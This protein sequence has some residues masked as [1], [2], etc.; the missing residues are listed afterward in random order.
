[1]YTKLAQLKRQ[2]SAT[3]R[4]LHQP[5]SLP[6]AFLSALV[7]HIGRYFSDDHRSSADEQRPRRHG[8]PIKIL[9]LVWRRSSYSRASERDAPLGS[10][11]TSSYVAL[12]AERRWPFHCSTDHCRIVAER[13]FKIIGERIKTRRMADFHQVMSSRLPENFKYEPRR[14]ARLSSSV[15]I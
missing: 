2:S 11:V 9:S 13:F 8:Q 4:I 6:G 7:S 3:E 5:I 1:M 14:L 12:S 10:R 15:L